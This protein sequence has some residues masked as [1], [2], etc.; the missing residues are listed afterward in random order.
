MADKMAKK[1]PIFRKK[2]PLVQNWPSSLTLEGVTEFFRVHRGYFLTRRSFL[3]TPNFT[4]KTFS[5]CGKTLKFKKLKK[6]GLIDLLLKYQ[7]VS[8]AK[9]K[10]RCCLAHTPLTIVVQTIFIHTTYI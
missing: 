10:F 7:V 5:F 3:K 1:W 2:T 8:I 4:Q 6:L 9:Q